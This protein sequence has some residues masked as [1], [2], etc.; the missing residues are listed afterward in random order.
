M[1]DKLIIVPTYNERENIQPLLDGIFEVVPDIHVLF[2]DDNSPDK[3]GEL[4]RSISEKDARIHHLHREN[5]EGLGRAYVAGFRW[6]LER[7][8]EFVFEMDADRSHDPGAL[9]RMIETAES[10]DLVLGSRYV[11]GIR[12]INW[13][14]NRLILSKGAALYVRILTGM[15][16]S[17][18][19]GGYKCFRRAVLETLDLDGVRSSGY[20]FQI[21]MTYKAWTTGFKVQETPITFIERQE[22]ES[23]M[24]AGI[25]REALIIVWRLLFK[26]RFKRSAAKRPHPRSVVVAAAG[27]AGADADPAP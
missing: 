6:A 16:F 24:S 25:I 21:E 11:G 10:C 14:L 4:A 13:P 17:D 7:G 5:K 18:P 26:H 12:V 27:E 15:P 9:P 20:S 2:V 8:Y 22:G 19:T 3:T 23:K 1:S